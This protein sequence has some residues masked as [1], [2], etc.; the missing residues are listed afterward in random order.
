MVGVLIIAIH[1]VYMV[2]MV[3]PVVVV[4]DIIGYKVEGNQAKQVIRHKEMMVKIN[5][6]YIQL[7][8][9]AELE[10][11]HIIQMVVKENHQI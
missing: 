1:L 5:M 10:N 9:V 7:V 4:V 11:Y 6:M 8:V 3:H 2:E